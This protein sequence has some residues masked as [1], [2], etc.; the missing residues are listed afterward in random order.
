MKSERMVMS[1]RT[2]AGRR[3]AT[4]NRICT[5]WVASSCALVSS[6]P[7]R[8][9]PRPARPKRNN[10]SN[11][12]IINTSDLPRSPPASSSAVPKLKLDWRS[13]HSIR[14]WRFAASCGP[15]SAASRAS[16]AA[17]RTSGE[18]PGRMLSQTHLRP[19]GSAR[20]SVRRPPRPA[21]TRDD[22]PQP[23]LP[24]TAMKELSSSNS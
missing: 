24:T 20:S 12:S 6:I 22:L 7:T 18:A 17:R 15:S 14:S 10:S 2:S 1:R 9:N 21:S 23:E 5:N 4:S 13:R 16:A 19:P 11:W 3:L 8:L